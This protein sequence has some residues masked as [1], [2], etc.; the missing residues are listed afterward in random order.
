MAKVG[1]LGWENLRKGQH[2]DLK[3]IEEIPQPRSERQVRGIIF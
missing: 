1:I 3:E 2:S